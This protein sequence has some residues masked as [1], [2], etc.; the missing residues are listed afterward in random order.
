VNA[1][2]LVETYL[3]E[4]APAWSK[5][6]LSQAGR[7]LSDFA[8]FSPQGAILAEDVIAYVADLSGRTTSKGQPLALRSIGTYLSETRRLL[9]WALVR[10][11]L[12]LDLASLI[13]TRHHPALPRTLSEAEIEALIDKSAQD[14][15]E[16][17][18]IEL[19]YG[20]GLRASELCRLTVDDV[21]LAEAQLYVRCGKGKKDRVVPFG[22]RVRAALLAYLRECRP[23]K[24]GPLFLSL[25]GRSLSCGHLGDI[26]AKAGRRAGITRPVSPHR[27]RHSYATHLL[28]N[29]ADIR[30]I[31]LLMGHA[32]LSS[33][34][35]YLAVD[36]ADLAHMLEK[37]HPRERDA[38]IPDQL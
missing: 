7:V 23:M 14:A 8:R 13:V 35:V 20:T 5:A 12:L 38:K 1:T 34:Q 28:R 37:S 21:D 33:T 18:I 16:R 31:Q 15:R 10:G 36:V 22:E 11:H 32:S 2:E 24:N 19:L 30:H 6:T 3:K 29:G 9:R 4:K 26:V 17:A 27:L 25:S